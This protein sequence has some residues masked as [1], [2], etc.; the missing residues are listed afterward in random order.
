M[1]NTSAPDKAKNFLHETYIP[2]LQSRIKANFSQSEKST[3]YIQSIVWTTIIN[4]QD[5]TN[6]QQLRIKDDAFQKKETVN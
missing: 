6:Q 5:S 1:P 3:D 2:F 4:F